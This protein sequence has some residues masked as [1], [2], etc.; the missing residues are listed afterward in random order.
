MWW[1]WYEVFWVE[2]KNIL[3]AAVTVA[4]ISVSTDVVLAQTGFKQAFRVLNGETKLAVGT[5]ELD[6]SA[7]LVNIDWLILDSVIKANVVYAKSATLNIN[8]EILKLNSEVST[9]S[10]TLALQSEPVRAQAEINPGKL[11][12][13]VASDLAQL[14]ILLTPD[15]VDNVIILRTSNDIK[16]NANSESINKM[17]L[18]LSSAVLKALVTVEGTDIDAKFLSGSALIV[19]NCKELCKRS[20]VKI[21]S[22]ENTVLETTLAIAGNTFV[23]NLVAGETVLT[24]NADPSTTSVAT[25]T[26]KNLYNLTG[27]KSK[28][29]LF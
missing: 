19:A 6:I 7:G 25:L 16:I 28:V 13:A 20:H 3:H 2:P 23:A 15:L 5:H 9:S 12:V 17:K 1:G 24:I 8:S 18:Q 10:F 4:P 27:R 11:D 29:H 14:K 22:G 21:A 26:Y